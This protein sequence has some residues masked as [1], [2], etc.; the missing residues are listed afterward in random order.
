M[1]FIQIV[2]LLCL[3]IFAYGAGD[4]QLPK[5]AGVSGATVK[6]KCSDETEAEA[7]EYPLEAV[8]LSVTLKNMLDDL[9]HD[10]IAVTPAHNT[11]KLPFKCLI[12]F[13]KFL[14]EKRNNISLKDMRTR[15]K[16]ITANYSTVYEN[17]LL[18]QAN[19][20]DFQTKITDPKSDVETPIK[21]IDEIAILHADAL[22]TRGFLL[23][24]DDPKQL[25]NELKLLTPGWLLHDLL[26]MDKFKIKTE[27]IPF[28]IQKLN[29]PAP[30]AIFRSWNVTSPI[31]SNSSIHGDF[32][33]L[34]EGN[35]PQGAYYLYTN[36]KKKNLQAGILDIRVNSDSK[37]AISSDGVTLLVTTPLDD[38]LQLQC[39]VSLYNLESKKEI[40]RL[41]FEKNTKT[42]EVTAVLFDN[43]KNL[44]YIIVCEDSPSSTNYIRFYELDPETAVLP[45]YPSKT[46]EMPRALYFSLYMKWSCIGENLVGVVTNLRK[47]IICVLYEITS[48]K[49]RLC[50]YSE[51]GQAWQYAPDDNPSLGIDAGFTV[52]DI[53][54][55]N[56]SQTS[57]AVAKSFIP[58]FNALLSNSF[59]TKPEELKK[60]VRT[61]Q[62]KE[63]FDPAYLCKNLIGF[64]VE[65]GYLWGEVDKNLLIRQGLDPQLA[66]AIQLINQKVNSG[67]LDILPD[68]YF[69]YQYF[70]NPSQWETRCAPIWE[71]LI[72]PDVKKIVGL[73]NF[74][75]QAT[76]ANTVPTTSTAPTTIV[77]TQPALQPTTS[78]APAGIVPAAPAG[79]IQPNAWWTYFRQNF[80]QFWANPRQYLQ[81]TFTQ[82]KKEILY[83]G[84]AMGGGLTAWL[85]LN[86][87]K[88]QLPTT[89]SQFTPRLKRP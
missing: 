49:L 7:S 77:P 14:V 18:L 38:M 10:P 75:P 67:K 25:P 85:L 31:I 32:V 48:G 72:S 56:Q 57:V 9:G 33:V 51:K 88:N 6:I 12:D 65:K 39:N 37:C 11:T 61:K 87:Y 27:Q 66:L 74:T 76:T 80:G 70:A 23:D 30:N 73:E 44:F 68:A 17:N 8:K 26:T 54:E 46:F 62:E 50:A 4:N 35:A 47:N 78:A 82:R 71:K 43:F 19:Y 40:A 16:D 64:Y 41:V 34:F 36:F 81:S 55:H 3:P 69:V 52:I 86:R 42:R 24:R 2:L 84:L 60:I 13:A 1:F 28:Q 20:L 22:K 79:T 29:L 21:M 89:T 53:L 15:F 59:K 58:N 63:V 45:L 83:G 5:A